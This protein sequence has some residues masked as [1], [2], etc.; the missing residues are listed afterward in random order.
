MK[1]FY[2]DPENLEKMRKRLQGNTFLSRGGN[3][4]LT[5][6]QVILAERLNLPM[7]YVIETAEVK[8]KFPSLP[9]CYKVD[10]AFP[11]HRLA[12]EVD[13]KT[14]RLKLWRFLDRRKTKVLQALGWSVLRFTNEQVTHSLDSVVAEVIE[15]IASKS[16]ET[17]TSSLMAS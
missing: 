7:E 11:Q 6:H 5:K 10:L 1:K 14:H 4:Q 12:I 8:D 13:G 2:S 16:K 3:G 9:H 15:F 17:T